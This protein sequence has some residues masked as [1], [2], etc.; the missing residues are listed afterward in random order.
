MHYSWVRIP[1]ELDSESTGLVALSL[2]AGVM[3]C[4]G[5]AAI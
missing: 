4:G 1:G 3:G 2:G 5:G